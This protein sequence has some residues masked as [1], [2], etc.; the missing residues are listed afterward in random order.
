MKLSWADY[1]SI[2][3]HQ[4]DLTLTSYIKNKLAPFNLAPEQNLIL[5]LLW[6]QDGLSQNDIAEKLDKDKTNIARMV[7]NLEHKGF[8]ERTISQH[9]RRSLKVYLSDKGCALGNEIIPITE[10]FNQLVTN[11]VTED[12]LKEFSRILTK[13]RNNVR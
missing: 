12:E 3:I 4:T 13:M 10:E 1:I 5:M 6:E 2:A 7:L 9:D 11:G 8:I